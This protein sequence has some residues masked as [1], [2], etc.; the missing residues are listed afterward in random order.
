MERQWWRIG[1]MLGIAFPILFLVVIFGV[2]GEEPALHAPIEEI[3][4]FYTDHGDRYLVG[5]YL[6]GLGLVLLFLPFVTSLSALLGRVEGAPAVCS[7]LVLVG[8]VL[9]VAALLITNVG[10]ALAMGA[11]DPEVDT[12]AVR[13]LA[14]V[15]TVTFSVTTL[16]VALMLLSASAVIWRTAVVWRWLALL[17]L[18]AALAGVVSPLMVL[19]GGDEEG[20]FGALMFL[21]AFPGMLLWTLLVGVNM[22]RRREL[23]G[24]TAGERSMLAD[25]QPL[26]STS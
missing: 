11:G 9:F 17:G 14:Y 22:V 10:S 1:G 2:Q 16:P 20:P 7:R 23:P 18:V 6:F 3:R 21:V 4:E 8:G 13:T 25:R 12:A 26:P 5:G 19:D 15:E 24:E